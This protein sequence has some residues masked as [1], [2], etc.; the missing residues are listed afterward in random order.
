[1]TDEKLIIT[2]EHLR[3]YRR[4]TITFEDIEAY[5]RS[6]PISAEIEKAPIPPHKGAPMTPRPQKEHLVDILKFDIKME[7]YVQDFAT[8]TERECKETVE[9]IHEILINC[10]R[11]ITQTPC[12]QP[13]TECPIR[14]NESAIRNATL[15][16][17][18]IQ[19]MKKEEWTRLELLAIIGY[20]RSR[21]DQ[22]RGEP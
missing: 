18:E 1:M 6:H 21:R 2:E 9:E 22:L 14:I 10:T 16:E 5:S 13:Y 12:K 19:I 8:F 3:N 17:I 20:H 4:G 7:K 11:P 15:D